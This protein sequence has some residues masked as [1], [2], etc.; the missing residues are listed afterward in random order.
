MNYLAI[1]RS[2]RIPFLVLTPVCIFLGASIA[3]ANQSTIDTRMLALV[4]IGALLAHISVN[5]LNEYQDFKSGLDLLTTKTPFSGGSGAL[6]ENPGMANT[7]LLASIL[8]LLACAGIGIYLYMLYGPGILPIG[9]AGLVL[10]VSYTR[11]VNLHPVLC[12]LA[13]G[14]GFGLLMVAGTQFVLQGHY[15]ATA[16]LAGG[17]PFFLVNNVLLLNQYPDMAADASAGRRTLPIVHG[18]KTS[19]RVYLAFVIASIILITTGV[20]FN[21]F[22]ALALAALAALPLALYALS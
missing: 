16:L 1:M 10:V 22:P 7:V 13:P 11:W 18:T 14:A 20:T 8:T 15:T 3:I 2:A 6:P 21:I 4:F 9:I 12:L 5:L 17:V 19:N